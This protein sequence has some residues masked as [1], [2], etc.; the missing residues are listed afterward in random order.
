MPCDQLVA[1]LVAVARWPRTRRPQPTPQWLLTYQE[2]TGRIIAT[3]VPITATQNQQQQQPQNG[4]PQHQEQQQ[5]AATGAVTA[6]ELG[7]LAYTAAYLG[8]LPSVPWQNQFY[9]AATGLLPAAKPMDAV[10]LLHAM[11]M[12]KVALQS[13]S[14]AASGATTTTSSSG[15]RFVYPAPLV[16][17][18]AYVAA[19]PAGWQ[20]LGLNGRIILPQCLHVLGWVPDELLV[21]RIIKDVRS[22]MDKLQQLQGRMQQ[23]IQDAE[24]A[25]QQASA[26]P[27]RQ[28]KA[29]ALQQRLLALIA[30]QDVVAGQQETC[31]ALLAAWEQLQQ[32]TL[33]ADS[34][35]S[36]LAGL[37]PQQQQQQLGW[38][39]A[40]GDTPFVQGSSSSLDVDSLM[41]SMMVAA[42][43]GTP[44]AAAAASA[45]PDMASVVGLDELVAGMGRI[46]GSSS[47]G[48]DDDEQGL[49][50]AEF[51]E[52]RG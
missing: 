4:S 5:Q 51:E 7:Q 6:D 14:S 19:S 21:G 42:G 35:A 10:Y 30:D 45:R 39:Q 12:W 16:E 22:S 33:G 32:P 24:A 49:I 36:P 15:T 28:Q 27:G 8:W 47:G 2:V 50:D 20:Q 17:A 41:A 29:A 43:L 46:G 44:A 52:V 37:D 25:L 18:L 48:D 9:L 13:G 40:T 34:Q 23:Q 11:S 38:Q 26:K 31:E 1:L 3:A